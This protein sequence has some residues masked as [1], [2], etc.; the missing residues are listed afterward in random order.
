MGKTSN[1]DKLTVVRLMR[2]I[3]KYVIKIEMALSP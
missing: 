2:V 1:R 3:L